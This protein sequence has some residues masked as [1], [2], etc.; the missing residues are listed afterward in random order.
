MRPGFPVI[1]RVV[2][3]FVVRPLCV[4]DEI[5]VGAQRQPFR[6]SIGQR[7]PMRVAHG[8]EDFVESWIDPEAVIP[9]IALERQWSNA[10]HPL[11]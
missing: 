1:R 7:N 4:L 3:R 5:S 8:L 2:D 11:L 6:P 9:E 10:C